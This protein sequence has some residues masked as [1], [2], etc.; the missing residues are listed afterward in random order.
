MQANKAVSFASSTLKGHEKNFG[1]I[2]KELL[3]IMWATKYF[4]L[5]LFGRGFQ[6]KIDHRPLI[7]LHYSQCGCRKVTWYTK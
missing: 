5:Y 4:R 1:T 7:W 6:I 3:A 2:K